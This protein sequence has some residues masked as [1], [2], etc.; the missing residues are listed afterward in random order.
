MSYCSH[1]SDN[2]VVTAD[3]NKF[4]RK[5]ATQLFRNKNK[6]Q[7]KNKASTTLK[8]KTVRKRELLSGNYKSCPITT[9]ST[10]D[11]LYLFSCGVKVLQ[12]I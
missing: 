7:Q 3:F 12:I 6:R 11:S 8:S 10:S 2:L 5:K 9:V 1:L 4:V